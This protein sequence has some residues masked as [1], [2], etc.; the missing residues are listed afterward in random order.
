MDLITPARTWAAAESATSSEDS[1]ALPDRMPVLQQ[2][3]MFVSVV[4]PFVGLV[5]AI[6]L[7]WQ[8]NYG[9]VGVGWPEIFVMIAAYA[10]TGFGVTI[11]YHRLLTHRAFET[12]RFMRLLLAI[13]GSAAAQGMA[14]RWWANVFGRCPAGA[15][16]EEA[17]MAYINVA[18]RALGSG[19]VDYPNQEEVPARER[20]NS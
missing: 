17:G 14:I 20:S 13:A 15:T 16:K 12:P 1:H 2:I 18:L 10:V 8:R 4:G 6:I 9:G 7:L 3:V 11:G 19:K 5:A